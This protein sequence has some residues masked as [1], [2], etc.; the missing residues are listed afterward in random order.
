M[1]HFIYTRKD[2]DGKEIKDTI[3][4]T[5]VIR[6][7]EL[8]EGTRLVLLDDIHKRRQEVPILNKKRAVTGYK[9]QE[10]TFQTEVTLSKEDSARFIQEIGG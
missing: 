3:N 4:L 7:I 9:N 8:E 2:K 10:D 5:K 1:T 6:S